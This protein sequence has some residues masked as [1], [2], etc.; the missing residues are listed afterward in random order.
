MLPRLNLE[1]PQLQDLLRSNDQL[2][3][4]KIY[5]HYAPV[6]YGWIIKSIPDKNSA[7][8]VFCT[9]FQK[10]IHDIDQYNPEKCGFLTWVIQISNKEIQ[11]FNSKVAKVFKIR[12][13]EIME[14][15]N[16]HSN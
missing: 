13:S 1:F 5:D 15:S 12:S 14:S 16:N 10:V 9:S 4:E 2:K 7:E 6:M 3:F 11:L 8:R